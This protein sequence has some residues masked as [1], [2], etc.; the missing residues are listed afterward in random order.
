MPFV[1]SHYHEDHFG[2]I[3][4]L[5]DMGVPVL[6]G[7]DRGCCVRD[8]DKNNATF[9]DYMRTVGW[10]AR[11]LR[12]GDHIDLDPLVTITCVTAGGAV[13]GE[14]PLRRGPDENDL[15][16]SI[17]I[18]FAG[19]RAF[20]GGDTEVATEAKLTARRLVTD[21]DLY[22]AN[23]HG[24][25][26]SSSADFMRD[27][28]P[29]VVVVSNGSHGGYKHPRG[30]TL[31]T[32][33]DLAKPP[34]VF[35]T[36]KCL[37][38]APCGNVADDRIA[39]LDSTTP[40]GT[41]LIS[42]DAALRRYVVQYGTT[43]HEFAVKDARLQ[44]APPPSR[45]NEPTPISTIPSDPMSPRLSSPSL[46][47]VIVL[48]CL[49][50]ALIFLWLLGQESRARLVQDHVVATLLNTARR[51]EDSVLLTRAEVQALVADGARAMRTVLVPTPDEVLGEAIASI[52]TVELGGV[53]GD[54]LINRANLKPIGLV[55]ARQIVAD[56]RREME[57]IPSYRLAVSTQFGIGAIVAGVAFAVG[58]YATGD[59]AL[60]DAFRN[61]NVTNVSALMDRMWDEVVGALAASGFG[62]LAAWIA[63][64]R[65]TR[66][67]L[68][69]SAHTRPGDSW[70]ADP[71]DA[72]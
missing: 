22:K 68:A 66:I 29:A 53:R 38:P 67:P 56:F 7:Y 71:S 12:P 63:A 51:E 50:A 14:V 24:S 23:H 20:F 72:S 10:G 44:D 11:A 48:M 18:T 5:V 9:L 19:F 60:G 31:A 25:D 59:A 13:E 41:I 21:V 42:V 26:S 49:P 69:Q 6:T 32:F 54:D 30:A 39:D 40:T 4:D 37:Y 70:N 43:R 15:S 45:S 65:R 17:L 47:Y 61:P 35:Q 1:N 28:R 36:N 55:K 58:V 16:V 3:D 46:W 2:G 52:L 64:R 34:M 62:G 27:L 57:Q 8:A 33:A